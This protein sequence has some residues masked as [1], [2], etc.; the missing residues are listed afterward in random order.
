MPCVFPQGCK[1]ILRVQAVDVRVPGSKTSPDGRGWAIFRMDQEW[2]AM[3]ELPCGDYQELGPAI[4]KSRWPCTN[5][6]LNLRS[7]GVS[8]SRCY[9]IPDLLDLSKQG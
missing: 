9:S 5:F 8:L 1:Y 6:I 3:G 2:K 4:V 7:T